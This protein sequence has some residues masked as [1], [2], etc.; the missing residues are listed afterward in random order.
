VARWSVSRVLRHAD[1]RVTVSG[2]TAGGSKR[3]SGLG[4]DAG[5]GPVIEGEFER[6]DEKPPDRPRVDGPKRS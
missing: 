4:D 2:E 1:I 3:A 5:Q 6:L